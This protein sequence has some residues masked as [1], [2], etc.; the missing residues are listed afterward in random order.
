MKLAQGCSLPTFLA[1]QST[2]AAASG[3]ELGVGWEAQRALHQL[4]A[5]DGS[6]KKSLCG[7]LMSSPP[8][9]EMLWLG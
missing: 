4:Q 2:E 1:P 9:E 8:A 7:V 5:R 3:K 6:R